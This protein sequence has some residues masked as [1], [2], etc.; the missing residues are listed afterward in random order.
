[1]SASGDRTCL[2]EYFQAGDAVCSKNYAVGDYQETY[3]AVPRTGWQF[4]GWR[5]YC[6]DAATNECSFEVAAA[7]VK[8]VW[9]QTMPPL[10]AVFT[11]SQCSA[12]SLPN[13]IFVLDNT[14]N[15][16][17]QSQQWPGGLVQGQSEVAAIKSALAPLVGKLNVGIVEYA[18]GGSTE[19]NNAGYVR[20]G[21]QELNVSSLAR[22]NAVLDEIYTSINDSEEKRSAGNAY[23]DL[24]WDFYNYLAGKA[25][26]NSGN[27]TPPDLADPFAYASL[28]D[29]FQSPLNAADGCADV[30][31]IFVGNNANGNIAADDYINTAG[32]KAAYAEAEALAPDALAGETG[33]TPLAIPVFAATQIQFPDTFVQKEIVPDQI[34]PGYA[35]EETLVPAADL[36][37]SGA[38]YRSSEQS[39]CTS[40]ENNSGELCDNQENCSCTAISNDRTGC[41][42][43]GATNKQTWRWIFHTDGWVIPAHW[44]PA[45]V[46]PGYV[47]PAHTILGKIVEVYEPTGELDTTGGLDY[48][49]D[50]WAKFLRNY[51]VPVTFTD[52]GNV[53][54]TQ[55]VRVRTYAIDVFNEQ[56]NTD[57]SQ[58]WF[59]AA[60]AGG[61]RYFQAGSETEILTAIGSVLSTVG[62]P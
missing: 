24:P 42:T 51:G 54:R 17:R 15:W 10:Q 23:G 25:H 16:S 37:V 27:G 12:A 6:T 7:T 9:G 59:S 11:A 49:F 18:T 32:L 61:G 62:A 8:K 19:D 53:R 36:G 48:N 31:A 38:C 47:I 40:A 41:K 13:V 60:T 20:F 4:D 34:I 2:L 46:I 43:Y 14:S 29:T 22:L 30:F 26:S 58:L 28:W 55:R 45:E 50:D 39:V 57:L 52:E 33:G 35:V 56:Q 5:N 44:V 1:M 3:Y 21:L